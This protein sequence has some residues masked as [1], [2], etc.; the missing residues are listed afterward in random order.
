MAYNAAFAEKIRK[1]LANQSNVEE[2]GMFGKIAFMVND[3]MCITVGEDRIMCRIDPA[4]HEEVIQKDGCQTVIMKGRPYI[5]YV[6]VSIDHIRSKA[7]FNYWISLALDFN[8][9]IP[10]KKSKSK[11]G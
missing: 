1:A 8:K 10:A 3:H 11:R 9:K 2:K 5:G 6:H 4:I 7:D